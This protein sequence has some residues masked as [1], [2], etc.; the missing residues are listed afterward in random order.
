MKT[1]PPVGVLEDLWVELRASKSDVCSRVLTQRRQSSGVEKVSDI[2]HVVP[3]HIMRHSQGSIFVCQPVTVLA[4]GPLSPVGSNCLLEASVDPQG[5]AARAAMGL[6]GVGSV[7]LLICIASGR[8]SE[9]FD[10]FD[11]AP[12][13]SSKAP[14]PQNPN[15]LQALNVM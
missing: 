13:A 8:A 9:S 15:R 6:N 4:E 3:S 14:Q 7:L 10:A 5:R 2:Q 1:E 11:A 12:A